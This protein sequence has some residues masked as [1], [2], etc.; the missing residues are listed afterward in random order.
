MTLVDIEVL[1]LP[2]SPR[3]LSTVHY[4][5]RRPLMGPSHMHW[6]AQGYQGQPS[7]EHRQYKA[8]SMHID[9]VSVLCH[10]V[11]Q[12][13][14]AFA[15]CQIAQVPPIIV[16][17][18]TRLVVGITRKS[19]DRRDPCRSMVSRLVS[20]AISSSDPPLGIRRSSIITHGNVDNQL[21]ICPLCVRH[22]AVELHS[23]NRCFWYYG[24]RS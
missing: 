10:V 13:G 14:A 22:L 17:W 19:I 15:P 1:P 9:D 21:F 20:L 8:R 3:L 24:I 5:L 2:V 12:S 23:T 11:L 16:A 6:Q 4:R 7:T 18:R